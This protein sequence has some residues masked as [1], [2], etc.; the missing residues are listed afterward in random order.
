MTTPE[1][2]FEP[3]KIVF[4][5]SIAEETVGKV[6]EIERSVRFLGSRKKLSEELLVGYAGTLLNHLP[7]VVS[8][9]QIAGAQYSR[10]VKLPDEIE[11]QTWNQEQ[12]AEYVTALL[13]EAQGSDV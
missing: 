4:K 9:V 7:E 10:E 5:S 12:I 13:F 2:S 8:T 1:E 6:N 11:P 3:K